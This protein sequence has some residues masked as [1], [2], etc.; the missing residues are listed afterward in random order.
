MKKIKFK[1]NIIN[2]DILEIEDNNTSIME[3]CLIEHPN[4]F[5]INLQKKFPNLTKFSFIN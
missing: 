4:D 1:L 5:L 3:I 2:K